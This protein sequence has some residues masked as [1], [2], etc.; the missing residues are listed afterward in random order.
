M[1][2]YNFIVYLLIGY[3]FYFLFFG[4]EFILFIDFIFGIYI[5]IEFDIFFI[6][7]WVDKYKKRFREVLYLVVINIEKNV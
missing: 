5:E 4:R 3:F 2:V 7:E 6:D 1:Y